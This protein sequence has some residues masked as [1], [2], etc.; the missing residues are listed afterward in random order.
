MKKIIFIVVSVLVFNLLLIPQSISDNMETLLENHKGEEGISQIKKLLKKDDINA[1]DKNGWTAL[2]FASYN[3]HTDIV[4]ELIKLD[5]DVNIQ[6]TKTDDNILK[7]STA[8][9]IATI[10]SHIEIVEIL[11]NNGADVNKQDADGSTAL[12]IA[13]FRGDDDIVKK[14]ISSKANIDK[15]NNRGFTALMY[16]SMK[17]N[18]DI[19][20][21]LISKGAD[22]NKQTDDGM[23]AL[24]IACFT[25]DYDIVKR[26]I[27]NKANV[28]KQDTNGWTSLMYASMKGN[29]DIVKT[30]I[31]KGVDVN[32]QTDDGMTALMAA[33]SFEHN[34][35]ME[36]LMSSGAYIHTNNKVGV[37][38][39]QDIRIN[40]R[41]FPS[42][43]SYEETTEIKAG[44][45]FFLDV[46]VEVEFTKGISLEKLPKEMYAYFTIESTDKISIKDI[47]LS[48]GRLVGEPSVI[49]SK[50]IA[51][52]LPF[53]LV[54]STSLSS[55]QNEFKFEI[56]PK[57]DTK[58]SEIT[59]RLTF[60]GELNH[61]STKKT[62]VIKENNIPF[63]PFF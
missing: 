26:L 19:M 34:K 16:A 10:N 15:Q 5:A 56:T 24:M 21:I 54:P 42:K 49:N 55:I 14:L 17:G 6:T 48:S 33:A 2:M 40:P 37:E 7:L 53:I 9:M 8:L 22:V 23:T 29:N 51:Y 46:D 41:I 61:Y 38:E 32:K 60:D 18:N 47:K 39:H 30:L 36:I 52:T 50:S 4:K 58:E 3:G 27:S 1:K 20:K 31:S 43:E 63:I 62:I 11:I 25:G 59:I 57:K 28:N 44:K 12:M 45:S 13:C 35:T